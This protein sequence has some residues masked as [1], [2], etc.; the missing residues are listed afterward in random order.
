MAVIP[1][2]PQDLLISLYSEI[3]DWKERLNAAFE[4]ACPA[5]LV[6]IANQL[7]IE[8]GVSNPRETVIGSYHDGD[9]RPDGSFAAPFATYT[10]RRKLVCM[11]AGGPIYPAWVNYLQEAQHAL[12][13]IAAHPE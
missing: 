12:D 6:R 9:K 2:L 5:R 4:D 13:L 7:A 11:A 8:D 3:L 10:G 1:Q